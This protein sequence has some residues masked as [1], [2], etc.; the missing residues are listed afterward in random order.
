MRFVSGT[1]ALDAATSSPAS[2]TTDDD[3]RARSDLA[4]RRSVST[5]PRF[6]RYGVTGADRCRARH[7][8]RRRG[9]DQS[10]SAVNA[11]PP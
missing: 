3:A 9:H 5:G 1:A 6:G 10:T 7:R 2:T 8:C 11:T 4:H